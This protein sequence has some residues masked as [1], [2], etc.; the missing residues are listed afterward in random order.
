MPIE[1][2]TKGD[3]FMAKYLYI[4]FPM[5]AALLAVGVVRAASPTVVEGATTVG[6]PPLFYV[7]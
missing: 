4:V 1:T 5:I 6:V 2:I 7:E 3:S